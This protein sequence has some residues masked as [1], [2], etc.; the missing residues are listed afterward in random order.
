VR[1]YICNRLKGW[2]NE[3]NTVCNDIG[4]GSDSVAVVHD[5]LEEN[6][7][8]NAAVE[9]SRSFSTTVRKFY[10]EAAFT[11][12]K[13]YIKDCNWNAKAKSL[14]ILTLKTEMELKKGDMA[15]SKEK[16]AELRNFF[17]KLHVDNKIL[18][19]NDAVYAFKLEVDKIY[20]NKP[21]LAGYNLSTLAG[22]KS[23]ISTAKLSVK[24]G[25]DKKAFEAAFK[26]WSEKVDALL[27]EPPLKSEQ[28]DK[29]KAL[30]DKFYMEYGIDF[31]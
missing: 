2:N 28:A 27:A 29:L 22:L 6:K 14:Y 12:P 10:S 5:L 19:T 20:A 23:K 9:F 21:G 18:L 26:Q 3:K 31:E 7:I 8:K 17:Y 30:T 13:R 4:R 15:A 16:L 11:A 25:A 1:L 24:A